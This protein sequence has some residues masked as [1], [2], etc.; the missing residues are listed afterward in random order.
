MTDSLADLLTQK[1]ADADTLHQAMR[2][3]VAESTSDELTVLEMRDILVRF[4]GG[5]VRLDKALESLRTN[6]H[7]MSEASL[8]VLSGAWSDPARREMVRGS[9]DDAKAKAPVIEVGILAIVVMY[10]MYLYR[11]CG[12][13]VEQVTISYK[14][15]EVTYIKRT[16]YRR[17][18]DPLAAVVRLFAPSSDSPDSE[19]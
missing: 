17:P 8:R 1:S 2:Y 11:T 18:G 15:G 7:A 10:G 6:T 9:I 19:D 3:V 13:A 12:K 14:D 5:E 16:E 4:V